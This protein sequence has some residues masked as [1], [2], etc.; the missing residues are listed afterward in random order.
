MFPDEYTTFE[1][2]T[3]CNE[4]DLFTKVIELEDQIESVN[5]EIIL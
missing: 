3:E 5:W 4:V 2:I 1:Y